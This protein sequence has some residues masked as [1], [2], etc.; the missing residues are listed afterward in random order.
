MLVLTEHRPYFTDE[1]RALIRKMFP[2]KV[3]RWEMR[4]IP[5]HAHC[6]LEPK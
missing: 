3:I 5:N 2:E 4:Q 6:H 1:E